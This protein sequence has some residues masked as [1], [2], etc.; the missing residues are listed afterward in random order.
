METEPTGIVALAS[1]M[2]VDGDWNF[3]ILLKSV[4]DLMSADGK[5]DNAKYDY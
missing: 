1:E 3:L 2:V 4:F 5:Q